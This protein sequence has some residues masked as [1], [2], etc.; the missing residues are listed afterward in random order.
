MQAV[1]RVTVGAAGRTRAVSCAVHWDRTG[2]LS[3]GIGGRAAETR[4]IADRGPAV[5]RW[6]DGVGLPVLFLSRLPV[7]YIGCFCSFTF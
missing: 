5:G 2:P 4:R 1:R 3:R 7:S 6:T